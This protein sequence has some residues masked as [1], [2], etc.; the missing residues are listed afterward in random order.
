MTAATT[1]SNTHFRFRRRLFNPLYWHL[2]KYLRDHSIRYI[3][4]EGGSSAGKTMTIAQALAIDAAEHKYG[5]MVF[6]KFHV[7]IQDSVYAS[8][9]QAIRRLKLRDKV[10]KGQQDVFKGLRNEHTKIRF[11]G[12]DDPENIKGIEDYNVIY[13]NEWNQFSNAEFDQQRKRLRGRANQK[14]ICDWNPISANLWIYKEVID[15]D[16]WTDLPLYE[17]DAPTRFSALNQE[18]SFIRINKAKN[19]IHIKVTYRDNYYVVGHPNGKD[20]F[21]DEH[22]LADFEYDRLHKPNLY[23]VYGNGER[24]IMRTG[25]EFFKQFNEQKHV[26]P[27]LWAPDLPFHVTVDENVSPYVTISIWQL[28]GKKIRQVH[29]IACKTPDNNAIKAARKL[30]DWLDRIEYNETVFVYGDPSGNKRS[31][32]DVDNY[33]FF[34]KFIDTLQK[35]RKYKVRDNVLRAHPRVAISGSFINEI[36]EFEFE[37][38]SI[39]ISDTCKISIDDY[40]TVKEDKNGKM[41]KE[42]AKHPEPPYIEY[43]INGHFSDAM[44]YFICKLLDREFTFFLSRKQRRGSVA[45]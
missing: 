12:L 15:K 42:K 22:T 26:K 21:I 38:Y 28:I 31:T 4:I 33:S 6:R 8:F 45:A 2:K 27:C 7:H 17:K 11:R 19:S 9:K 39:E 13:N 34:K 25:Q 16:E 24:G 10:Y 43:E 40:A 32:V 36:F 14:I 23:R 29:E 41:L 18:H 5:V 37:G 44:R 30:A 3:Y 1:N 35:E 20:G